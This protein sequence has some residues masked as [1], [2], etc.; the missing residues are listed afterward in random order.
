MKF[1]STS[2]ALAVI[3][4]AMQLIS[5]A[6]TTENTAWG[7]LESEVKADE[8]AYVLQV[9]KHPSAVDPV[10]RY[11]ESEL[12]ATECLAGKVPFVM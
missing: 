6:P 12:L 10:E 8:L 1:T 4:L 3:V 11:V 2:F 5:A 7:G 9:L